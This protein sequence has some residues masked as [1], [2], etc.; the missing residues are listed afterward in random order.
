MRDK[1]F[2]PGVPEAH[3][4]GRLTA[5]GGNEI[6]SGKLAHPESSAALAANAFGW[7]VN[8]PSY[9][10]PLPGTTQMGLAERVEVEFCARLPWSGGRHPWL[11]AA[12]FTSS[13]L[14]GIE[15]KRFEPFRDAKRVSLP[16]AYDRPVWGGRMRRYCDVRD[17]LRRGDL[18]FTHLDGAQLV[19]HGYGLLTE[20]RRQGKEPVLFYLFAEPTS[21]AV[22]PVP[23]LYHQRHRDE[24]SAFSSAVAGDEVVFLSA[25]YREW[26]DSWDPDTEAAQYAAALSE[27]FCL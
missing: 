24:I 15:S 4:R 14:I 27:R 6:G 22:Q 25:S 7:F 17:A 13:H 21:R 2:L 8:Q 10:P 3:V 16:S 11:D 26:L 20:G 5:A 9:L 19:K 23:L 12:V 1:L 18:R